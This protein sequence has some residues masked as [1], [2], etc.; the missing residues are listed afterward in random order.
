MDV[1]DDLCDLGLR[2]Y[3]KNNKT[4]PH[5]EFKAEY[6]KDQYPLRDLRSWLTLQYVENWE[7]AIILARLACLRECLDLIQIGTAVVGS[8]IDPKRLT[9]ALT[10]AETP[11]KSLN[12]RQKF[13]ANWRSICR[14]PEIVSK[15]TSRSDYIKRRCCAMPGPASA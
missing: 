2:T 6:Q 1:L 8:Q 3:Q 5:S 11:D 14:R 9:A 10:Y 12:L 4:I 15:I 7:A 13:R